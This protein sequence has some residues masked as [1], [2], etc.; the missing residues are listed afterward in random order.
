MSFL[1][2]PGAAV[3]MLGLAILMWCI[4]QVVRARRDGLEDAAMRAKLQGI[5]AWNMA[6][7]GLSAIGLMMVVVGI[8]L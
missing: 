7:L 4:L 5:V 1:I 3:T 6:A 2:W 8:F